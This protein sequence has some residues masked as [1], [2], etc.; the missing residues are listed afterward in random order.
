MVFEN[1]KPFVVCM[2]QKFADFNGRAS[3]KE[4]WTFYLL[5]IGIGAVLRLIDRSYTLAAIAN[6]AFLVPTLACGT[7]RLH[8]TNRSGWW[9]LLLLTVVGTF[10]L[11]FFYASKGDVEINR[12]GQPPSV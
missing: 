11:I 7:R 9:Q 4:F 5:C 12:Y 10:P 1:W 3:R 8:D 6:L 2:T